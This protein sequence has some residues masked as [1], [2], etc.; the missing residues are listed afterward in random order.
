MKDSPIKV[1]VAHPGSEVTNMN[2]NGKLQ[3]DEGAKTSVGLVPLSN[4]GYNGKCHTLGKSGPAKP[5]FV[6]IIPINR[7]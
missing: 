5:H 4:S 6:R 1:N 2:A 3:A 7:I